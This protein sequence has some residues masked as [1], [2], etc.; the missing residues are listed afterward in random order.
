MKKRI[1]VLVIVLIGVFLASLLIGRYE[2]TLFDIFKI[3]SGKMDNK[4]KQN[5]FLNIRLPRAIFVFM[6]GSML[7]LA[8]FIYQAIFKNQLASPDILGVSSG[9]SLGAIIG[10]LFIGNNGYAIQILAFIVSILTVF[11]AVTTT[12]LM[13]GS[14]IYNLII[15]GI[16]IGALINV[17]IMYL[18][19]SADP[20]NQLAQIEYF[21]MGSFQTI[22]WLDV[23]FVIVLGLPCLIVSLLL[24][25]K[26]KIL[27]LPDDEAITLGLN[28]KLY[29]II[30]IIIST[31]L[32][33]TVVSIA[34]IVSW[35]G[36]VVPHLARMIFKANFKVTL[37]ISL[38]IGS[39]LLGLADMLAR[40]LT[41]SELPI[42]IL[43]SLIGAIILFI[44]MIRRKQI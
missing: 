31:I 41:Q 21:M 37:Y 28:V 24:E 42:S 8:G 1:A 20:E 16:I 26:L 15:A 35:I 14:K 2:L 18:K 43:T 5:V 27:T 23:I 19:Y 12:K 25:K 40:S 39:I 29:R 33:S 6:A 4:V 17:G 32:V 44:F 11:L 30:F 34:G 38:I 3:I 36:L 9:A 13:K 10:I 7:A 22:K